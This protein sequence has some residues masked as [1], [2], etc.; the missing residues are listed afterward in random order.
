MLKARWWLPSTPSASLGVSPR[1]SPSLQWCWGSGDTLGLGEWEMGLQVLGKGWGLFAPRL[2][3]VEEEKP[4]QAA[5]GTLRP[6]TVREGCPRSGS[7]A[8]VTLCWQLCPSPLLG[9][10][11][12]PCAPAL[13]SGLWLC[14]V[15]VLWGSQG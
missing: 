13:P 3:C 5:L 7:R 4:L 2:S 10:L 9:A 15:S 8:G 1:V 11:D 14:E 12:S 6:D